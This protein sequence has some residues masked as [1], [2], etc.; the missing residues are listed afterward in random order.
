MKP[1][2]ARWLGC[3]SVIAL[4]ACLNPLPDDTPSSAESSAGPDLLV[5]G[6]V[7]AAAPN[8]GN[9]ISGPSGESDNSTDEPNR[10]PSAPEG[11]PGGDGS[12]AP[13]AGASDGGD[14]LRTSEATVECDLAPDAGSSSSP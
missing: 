10:N 6:D 9:A 4:A 13:D 11:V 5:P 7:P 8:G 3:A 12:G 1:R 14:A 2:V